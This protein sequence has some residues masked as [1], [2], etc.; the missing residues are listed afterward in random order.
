MTLFFSPSGN[1][2]TDTAAAPAHRTRSGHR[3][4][5][6]ATASAGRDARG[7]VARPWRAAFPAFRVVAVAREMLL[8]LASAGLLLLSE[9]HLATA[10][11]WGL[12]LVVAVPAAIAAAGGYAWRTLG[13]GAVESPTVLRAGTMVIVTLM[14]FGYLG[15]IQVPVM[16]VA[17][18]VPAA[19]AATL[20]GRRI[21]RHSVVRRRA[22]GDAMMRT[23]VVGSAAG[24]RDLIAEIKKTPGAGY[25]IVGWCGAPGDADAPRGVVALGALDSIE[26]VADIVAEHRADVVLLVGEHGPTAARRVSWALAGTGASLVVVPVVSEI[27]SSRVRV[28]PTGDMWSLQLDVAPRRS[29]VPGKALVD[30]LL[31]AALLAAAGLVLA[32]VL[33]AVR[34]SSPG[35]PL[36]KQ[37]RIGVDGKPFTMWKVRSMYVDADARRAALMEDTD[38][39][40]LLFKMRA[41]P[42]ITPI[43]R[44]LRR[45]SIDEL[46]QLYNVVRG[47]MSIVGP[48]PALAEETMRYEGDE[49]KRL[50]VKPGLTGLWQVSGR[51]DLTREESMRLDLRYIDNWSLGLDASILS[52]TFRAVARGRGAY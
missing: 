47:E 44:V 27:A 6:V 39:N 31:G 11:A 22:K 19:V 9:P 1:D 26:G 5:L 14:V 37:Q 48:R 51:S 35:S 50:A 33:V 24:V 21:A 18:A 28:R 38:G 15:L 12:V 43:G 8:S 30:R 52:R 41:D 25:D 17:A 34:L 29:S 20:A 32:P 23:V 2:W 45:L 10:L 16:L 36:Y 3:L 13:E 4:R 7:G 46:P 40:G 49:P 42:R